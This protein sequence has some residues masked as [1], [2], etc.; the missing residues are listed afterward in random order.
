[1]TLRLTDS[2]ASTAALRAVFDDAAVLGAMLEFEV[3]LARAEATA[4]VIP[5]RAADA[6]T[7]AAQ[8]FQA[9]TTSLA[10]E[11]RESGTVTIPV[12][13][14]LT[15][16]VTAID[17]D[18]AR[19]VHFGATSQDVWDTAM[20]LCLVRAFGMLEADHRRIAAALAALS[21]AHADTIML[22]RTLLQPAT[23]VTFGL[24]VAGWLAAIE[25]GWTRVAEAFAGARVLQFGGATGTL[26]ALG[27]DGAAVEDGM[28]AA[29]NLARPDA[30]WHAHRDRL[31]AVVTACGLYTASLGKMARDV[32]LLMQMEVGEADEPGGGSSTMP[33]KRN[34]AG[35]AI[36]LAAAT[37]VPGLVG[38]CLS[39]M[40]Q[41]HERA[42]GGWHAEA[43]TIVA[44]VETTGSA[45]AAAADIAE[46]LSVHGHRMGANIDATHGVVFAERATLLAS[47]A[48]GKDVATRLVSAAVH[49]TM[50]SGRLFADVVQSMPELAVVFK[51]DVLRGLTTPGDYLGSAERFRRQLLAS[52]RRSSD[53]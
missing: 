7:A 1:M 27:P 13:R 38:T 2:L 49:E 40:L 9:D 52:A 20:V 3:A 39:S 36:V 44:V 48:L 37:R 16:R 41:E 8:S 26:A 28:A 11:A 32:S 47:A 35:C 17:A 43:P 51:P 45:M 10:R 42:V 30:P 12:V 5:P 46:G 19:F 33:H 34:P 22:G 31:G 25:R 14:A 21:D 6:I 24:K 23:P 15:A 18:S 50:R 4:G 29:L 53:R